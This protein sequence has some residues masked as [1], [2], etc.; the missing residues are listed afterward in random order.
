MKRRAQKQKPRESLLFISLQISQK[1]GKGINVEIF[2]LDLQT[3]S[4]PSPGQKKT[5]S[6]SKT[7]HDK[8]RRG[9]QNPGPSSLQ[10]TWTIFFLCLI[11]C[12]I[13]KPKRQCFTGKQEKMLPYRFSFTCTS[14][15]PQ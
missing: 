13:P 7:I 2:F 6:L 14:H 15:H 12:A 3:L 9:M 5:Q 4:P 8:L 11:L 1:I 10:A